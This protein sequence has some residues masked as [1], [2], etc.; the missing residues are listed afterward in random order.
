MGLKQ[1]MYSSTTTNNF[2]VFLLGAIGKFPSPSS[3]NVVYIYIYIYPKL[4]HW[5]C[6]AYLTV[7]VPSYLYV[8]DGEFLQKI[9][10]PPP[11]PRRARRAATP[12]QQH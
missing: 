11:M 10:K 6:N 2:P 7:C 12:Q 9:Y 5:N 4:D 8:E 1:L 3:H